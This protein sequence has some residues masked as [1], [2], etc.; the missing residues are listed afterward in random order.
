MYRARVREV[1]RDEDREEKSSDDDKYKKKTVFSVAALHIFYIYIWAWIP[2][3]LW[4]HVRCVISDRNFPYNFEI[5]MYINRKRFMYRNRNKNNEQKSKIYM[6][7]TKVR[8]HARSSYIIIRILKIAA[9]LSVRTQFIH[10]LDRSIACS[11]LS[12]RIFVYL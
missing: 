6:H 9:D 4:S 1:Q 2:S 5:Y 7:K 11:L 3:A 8:S 12:H 10:S